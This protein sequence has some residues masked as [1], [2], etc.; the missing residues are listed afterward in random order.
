VRLATALA[1]GI[2]LIGARE[3]QRDDRNWELL[4]IA[5]GGG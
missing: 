1:D 5:L 3:F 4:A 2:V